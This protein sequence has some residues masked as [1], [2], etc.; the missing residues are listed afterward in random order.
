MPEGTR[1]K[2]YWGGGGFWSNNFTRNLSMRKVI[3]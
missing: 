2:I 1:R 3:I